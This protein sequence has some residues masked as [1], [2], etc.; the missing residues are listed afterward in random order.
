MKFGQIIIWI[1]LVGFGFYLGNSMNTAQD[2]SSS[3]INE[4]ELEE[5]DLMP[6]ITRVASVTE[7]RETAEKPKVDFHDGLVTDVEK[8]TVSLFESSAPSVVFVTSTGLQRDRYSRNVYEI[9]KGTGSGFIWDNEGH[10]VTNYHV[11]REG[12]K[13]EITLADQTIYEAEMVGF[14]PRKDIAVLKINAPKEKLRA[15]PVGKSYNLKV[16]Q[17]VFA[18]GNPFGLDQTLTTGVISALGREIESIARVPIRDCIQTDAAINPGN[19]GGPLLNSSG[20]LIGVNTAIYSPSGA[21]AGI[22]FSIPVDIVSWVVPD[23]IQ[24]GEVQRPML[25][26]ELVAMQLMQRWEIKGAMI[27]AVTPNGSAAKSGLQD[28]QTSGRGIRRFGDIIVGINDHK[29]N[30]NNDLILALEKYKPGDLVTVKYIRD[31]QYGEL[32]LKLGSSL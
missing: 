15:L 23:L 2:V 21:S 20:R 31:E 24:Y 22:G 30:D 14:E 12:Q 16:G 17:S 4:E 25:G 28:T 27:A 32:E 11:V 29:I 19:S 18:I 9:P 8:A 5:K 6:E 1:A 7:E 10:I 13:W 26:V 3:D